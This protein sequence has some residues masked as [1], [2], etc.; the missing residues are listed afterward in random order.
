MYVTYTNVT[1]NIRHINKYCMLLYHYIF[2]AVANVEHM[3]FS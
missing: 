3:M 1:T 2:D